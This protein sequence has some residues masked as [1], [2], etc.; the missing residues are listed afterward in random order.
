MDERRILEAALNYTQS[1]ID[2]VR[3][4]MLVL[5]TNLRVVSANRSFFQDF[6][7]STEE[8][9][10]KHV[11]ELGNG[12][13]DIPR[14]RKLLEEIIP[15]SNFFNNFPVEHNILLNA[16]RLYGDLGNERI[17]LAME[18]VTGQPWT[19]KG[20]GKKEEKQDDE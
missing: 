2:T 3:E 10:G 12:Q 6:R 7:V 5:D 16:R 14:L 18:D 1:I 20:F 9:E 19:A 13:W 17:L 11:Y 8:T 4:P 15:R